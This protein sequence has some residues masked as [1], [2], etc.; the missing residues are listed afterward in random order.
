MVQ[1]QGTIEQLIQILGDQLDLSSEQIAS[2]LWLTVQRLESGEVSVTAPEAETREDLNPREPTASPTDNDIPP[3]DSTPS[4]PQP[5]AK[6]SVYTPRSS[7][8]RSGLSLRVPDAP[9][10]RDPMQFVQSLSA[11]MQRVLEGDD[12]QLDEVA[13]AEKTAREGICLPVLQPEPEPWLDLALII[14]ESQSMLL[15][16]QSFKELQRLLKNYG[17]FRDLR[18]WGVKPPVEGETPQLF[19]RT[20]TVRRPGDAK[21]IIDP[22]GRRLVLVVSDCVSSIWQKGLIFPWLHEWTQQQPLAILQML[23]EWMWRRTAL[24]LGE[25]VA[26]SSSLAGSPNRAL[27]V[28]KRFVW[29][30]RSKLPVFT[31]DPQTAGCWSQMV[32]G[33]ADTLV[34]GYLVPPQPIGEKKALRGRQET[35]AT[36]TAEQRVQRFRVMSSPLARKL[37]GLLAAA[38]VITLPVVR[39][40][41]A[42]LL[43]Q[44][45]QVQVAEVFLGGLLKPMEGSEITSETDPDRVEYEFVKSEIREIFLKDAPVRDSTDVLNAVSGYVAAQWGKTLDEFM[46]MLKRPSEEEREKVRPFAEVTVQILRQ[47]GE[48]YRQLAEELATQ[49]TGTSRELPVFEFE[50][51][52]VNRRGEI[53]QQERRTA[54]YYRERLGEG[55]SLD[56]VAIPGGTFQMGSSEGE[57]DKDEHP[58]HPV[59]VQPFFM[60]KTP[61]TQRQWY[62]VVTEVGMIERELEADPSRFKGDPPQPPLIRGEKKARTR[63]ERPVER[64]S[65]YE[66]V[67]FCAR[68]SQLTGKEYRLPSEAEWEYACRAGTE[69]PFH[70]G[71]TI[72]GELANYDASLTFADEPKGDYRKET[73]PVDYFPYANGFGLY[74]MHGNVWEW[75]LDPYHNN[76]KGA[77]RDGTVWDEKIKKND[78]RYQK[79]SEYLKPL[80]N[81]GSTKIVRGGSWYNLPGIC[82]SAYRDLNNPDGSDNLIGLRVVRSLPRTL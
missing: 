51:V 5:S 58:Q 48:E 2:I 57:G 41:Q 79:P 22:T 64:V 55:V 67:E 18:V 26:L 73:T 53:V 72:T 75:C 49:E 50:V 45:R 63:W 78:N 61:I 10:L 31:L 21:E 42:T 33:K 16:R 39:L 34:P 19:L 4:Q 71:E 76:Y 56:L 20:G 80:L 6:V 38:P 44:S 15:W 40:I 29:E 11:L 12:L 3:P 46:G 30:D 37:A 43:P 60:G 9:S 69:T 23:P 54:P 77:P 52:R 74:D 1:S 7:V 27:L 82:R 68:L 14:D 24:G 81:S 35:Q 25:A 28:N 66:A 8:G 32:V 59:T 36:Q 17:I 70:F 62:A 13:T 47:L 65:W